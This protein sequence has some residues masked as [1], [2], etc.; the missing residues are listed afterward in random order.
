MSN[1]VTLHLEAWTAFK[2]PHFG[3]EAPL[4]GAQHQFQ[5]EGYTITLTLPPPRRPKGRIESRIA[6]G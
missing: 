3:I 5:F 1:N 2:T 6:F 4:A